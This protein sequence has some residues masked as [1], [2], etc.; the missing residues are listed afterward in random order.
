VVVLIGGGTL[1]LIKTRRMDISQRTTPEDEARSPHQP[2]DPTPNDKD[3]PT[4]PD[5]HPNHP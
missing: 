4:R 3:T 5:T 1:F 2:D